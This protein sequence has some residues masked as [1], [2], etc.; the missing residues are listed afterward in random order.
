M[1]EVETLSLEEQTNLAREFALYLA[2]ER[3]RPENPLAEEAFELIAIRRKF[4]IPY[5]SSGRTRGA[6]IQVVELRK[7]L[8]NLTKVV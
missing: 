2:G 5:S 6:L 7:I 1:R 4:L 8:D 3:S